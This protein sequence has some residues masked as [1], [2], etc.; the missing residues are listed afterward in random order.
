V[1]VAS[2]L[3]LVAVVVAAVAAPALPFDPVQLDLSQALRP[4]TVAHLL[5]T[6]ELGRDL[7]TRIV[8]GG[9]TSIG[10]ALGSVVVATAAGILF[11]VVAGYGGGRVDAVIMQAVNVALSFPA[12][13]LALLMVALIGQG[14]ANLMVAIGIQ[15]V[16]GFVRLVRGSVLAVRAHEYVE[17][18]R[19]IG[20]A[21][22]RIAVIYILPN[23]VGPLAVQAT[24]LVAAGVQ[25]TSALSFL[26]IGVPPP[27]P[28]WGSILAGGRNYLSLAPHITLAPGL[29]LLFV[30]L[31]LNLLGDRLRDALDPRARI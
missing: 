1:T 24:F 15:A 28:E 11:G 16:P 9:R 30:L 21:P 12:V 6:D 26:G 5:G 13:L 4:P 22:S 17:A 2:G 7:L 25:L 20:C 10:I 19:A 18:A 23:L 29:V 3:L 27:T 14:V 31:A 8:Y